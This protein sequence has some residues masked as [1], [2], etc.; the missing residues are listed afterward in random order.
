MVKVEVIRKKGQAALV[1]WVEGG[2]VRRGSIPLDALQGDMVDQK[3]LQMAIP[4]GFPWASI[5]ELSVT[6]QIIEENLHRVGI[7]DLDDLLKN[8]QAAVGALQAAYKVD[9]AHLTKQARLFKKQKPG[10]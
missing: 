8:P 2:S 6:P 7:W 1:Q 10:G 9:V 3:M 4:A 5:I